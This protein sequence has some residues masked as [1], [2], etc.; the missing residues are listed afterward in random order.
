MHQS[1]MKRRTR[2]DRRQEMEMEMPAN[3]SIL[4]RLYMF[5]GNIQK[6]SNDMASLEWLAH[7]SF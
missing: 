1:L 7:E 3:L 2:R 4:L 6:R 5:I